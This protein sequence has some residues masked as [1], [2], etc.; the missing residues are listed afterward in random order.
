MR[1]KARGG[2]EQ[3]RMQ[4]GLG[5]QS[6]TLAALHSLWRIGNREEIVKAEQHGGKLLKSSIHKAALTNGYGVAMRL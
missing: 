4:S 3:M 2:F 6:I 1:R 5:H